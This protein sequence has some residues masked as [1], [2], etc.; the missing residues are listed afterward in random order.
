MKKSNKCILLLYFDDNSQDFLIFNNR[1]M[2]NNY[3]KNE[4]NLQFLDKRGLCGYKIIFGIVQ[5]EFNGR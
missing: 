1:N 3:F 2:V 5:E 4:E